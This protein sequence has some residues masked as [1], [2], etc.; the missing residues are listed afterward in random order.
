MKPLKDQLSHQ[1]YGQLW[2][3]FRDQLLNQLSD[4]LWHR[5]SVQLKDGLRQPLNARIGPLQRLD[6]VVE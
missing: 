3:Q 5:L 1:L 6:P 4:Q 2:Y